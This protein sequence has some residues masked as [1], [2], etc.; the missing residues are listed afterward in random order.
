MGQSSYRNAKSP[1]KSEIRNLDSALTVN[2]NILRLKV[3]VNHP[4]RMAKVQ[5]S[6]NLV[7]KFLV[8]KSTLIC[9]LLS[10]CLY[11]SRYFLKSKSRNSKIR[12]SCFSIGK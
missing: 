9:K 11:L 12:Y 6:N 3:P 5:C 1:R 2:E 10:V 4:S 8:K 7:Q